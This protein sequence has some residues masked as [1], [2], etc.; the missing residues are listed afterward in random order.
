MGKSFAQDSSESERQELETV[1]AALERTPKLVKLLRYLAEKYFAGENNHLTE[2]NI[3]TEVFD[4]KITSFIASEDAV[5]R[6]ETHR[7]RKKLKA[8]Y[9]GEGKSHPLQI[10]IP[11]G[12]YVPVFLRQ[13]VDPPIERDDRSESQEPEESFEQIAEVGEFLS[14]TGS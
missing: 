3:A 8:Y 2:Y 13:N 10:S 1:A 9:E 4:R 11:L 6:V 5:A 7:L 12:T 14:K